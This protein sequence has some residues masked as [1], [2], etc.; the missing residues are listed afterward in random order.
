MIINYMTICCPMY[1]GLYNL[2]TDYFLS[3]EVSM[4]HKKKTYKYLFSIQK[5]SATILFNIYF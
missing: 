3:T 1:C 5:K 4:S 2:I